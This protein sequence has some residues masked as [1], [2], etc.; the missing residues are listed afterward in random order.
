MRIWEA[1]MGKRSVLLML[2]LYGLLPL[3]LGLI[4]ACVLPRFMHGE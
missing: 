4:A 1:E 2:F 3:I